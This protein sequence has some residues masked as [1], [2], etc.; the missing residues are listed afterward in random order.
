MANDLPCIGWW[1]SESSSCWIR[2]L[3]TGGDSSTAA[4]TG[5]TWA[6]IPFTSRGLSDGSAAS[7]IELVFSHTRKWMIEQV[8]EIQLWMLCVYYISRMLYY[9]A[10]VTSIV[11]HCFQ[12]CPYHLAPLTPLWRHDF[13]PDSIRT[14]LPI[15]V[16]FS[17]ISFS[18]I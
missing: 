4:D 16:A 1:V 7:I 3:R 18:I 10:H 9:I 12:G 13:S 5:C 6:G 15:D 8:H 14:A 2:V 11:F 17:G